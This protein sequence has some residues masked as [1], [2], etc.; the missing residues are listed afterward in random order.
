MED[1]IDVRDPEIMKTNFR[2]RKKEIQL[3]FQR[4]Q[5]AELDPHQGDKLYNVP[6]T[7][8]ERK[9]WKTYKNAIKLMV[10]NYYALRNNS[11]CPACKKR[12]EEKEAYLKRQENYKKT[13]K[14]PKR[15]K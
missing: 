7:I 2:Y 3:T 15:K 4:M 11:N 9:D 14:K 6:Y 13:E 10:M 12:S 5:A 8:M 1:R